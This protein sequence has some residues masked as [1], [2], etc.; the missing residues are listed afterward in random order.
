[1]SGGADIGRG[2]LSFDEARHAY[3]LDGEE[4]IGVTTAL[5]V[6]GLVDYSAVDP[7]LLAYRATQGKLAHLACELDDLGDLDDTRVDPALVGYLAAWR[8]F[9]A[10]SG[11]AP[12]RVE[13]RVHHLVYRYAG[14]L[15][16]TGPLRGRRALVDIKTSVAPQPWWGAQLAAYEM[17][18]DDGPY[19]RF[20]VRLAND[21]TY[22]LDEFRDPNDRKLWLAALV[23]AQWRRLHGKG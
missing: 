23:I 19:D 14:T 11:F 18:L 15:D 21:G 3:S 6:A 9:R 20:A 17:C 13:H 16:R 1:M 7:K 22:R 10:E 4:L 8:R 5:Q 2:V 12:D